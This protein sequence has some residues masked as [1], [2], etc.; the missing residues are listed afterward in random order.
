MPI[1]FDNLMSGAVGGVLGGLASAWLTNAHNRQQ[2]KR[3]ERHVV[4]GCVYEALTAHARNTTTVRA[5]ADDRDLDALV[6]LQPLH[7]RRGVRRRVQAYK[8][9]RDQETHQDELGG[10]LVNNPAATDIAIAALLPDTWH[11]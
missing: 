2:A 3:A 9:A 4:A 6:S 5:G 7:K 10:V 11:G 8:A 1:T